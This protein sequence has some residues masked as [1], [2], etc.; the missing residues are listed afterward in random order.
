MGWF[1][2][3]K[4]SAVVGSHTHIPTADARI[5][6]HGTA[7]QTDTGMCGDYNSVIGFQKDAPLTQFLQKMRKTRLEPATGPATLSALFVETDDATGLAVAIEPL[8]L[9]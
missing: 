3:G 7:Y 1:L 5:L 6:P 8:Q 2:D 9:R 4:V